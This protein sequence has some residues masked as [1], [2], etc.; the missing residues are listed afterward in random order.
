[1]WSLCKFLYFF[2]FFQNIYIKQ[3]DLLR[4]PKNKITIVMYRTWKLPKVT[5][6]SNRV[7]H[8][9]T[10]TRQ[11]S[12]FDF[13]HKTFMQVAHLLYNP[14][15][16]T[17]W[18]KHS[19]VVQYVKSC[20]SVLHWFPNYTGI[21]VPLTFNQYLF[22][23]GSVTTDLAYIFT[24]RNPDTCIL[25]PQVWHSARNRRV[26]ISWAHLTLVPAQIRPKDL[27]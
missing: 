1:M 21:T 27:E 2:Y 24:N 10:P 9:W 23:C 16:T 8:V 20:V 13:P 22:S 4:F 18:R 7:C 15:I 12:D 14:V 11:P 3:T 25:I 5:R 17:F 19:L 26:A 6:V